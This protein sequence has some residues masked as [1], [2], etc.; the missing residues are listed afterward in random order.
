[1]ILT[2]SFD[3]STTL[4]G[5]AVANGKMVVARTDTPVGQMS[6]AARSISGAFGGVEN[7]DMSISE[8]GKELDTVTTAGTSHDSIKSEYVEMVY[9]AVREHLNYFRTIIAPATKT[10]SEKLYAYLQKQQPVSSQ[11]KIEVLE[12]PEPMRDDGF[13]TQLK[14][15]AGRPIS[16]TLERLFQME[17]ISAEKILE[18]MRTGNERKDKEISLWYARK[19]PAFF[20]EVWENVFAFN[21]ERPGSKTLGDML[22]DPYYRNDYALA[23]YLLANKLST[24]VMES[25]AMNLE[26]YRFIMDEI[27]ASSAT[28]MLEGLKV[29]EEDVV[30]D[31]VLIAGTY[32]TKSSQDVKVIYVHGASMRPWLQSGGTS[33][34]LLGCLAGGHNYRYVRDLQ[35]NKDTTTASYQMFL[36]ISRKTE[37]LTRGFRFR[38]RF[39]ELVTEIEDPNEPGNISDMEKAARARYPDFNNIFFRKFDEELRNLP[40]SAIA[41]LDVAVTNVITRSRFFYTYANKYFNN[42][43]ETARANPGISNDEAA[44]IATIEYVCAY[45]VDQL[46][47]VAV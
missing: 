37:E 39:R 8:F 28:A 43:M 2:S 24:E 4:A 40:D 11:L 14:R 31:N 16:R 15:F 35:E 44:L 34:Q 25:P 7:D 42:M 21:K 1:M 10:L 22:F 6:A 38:S 45:A 29:Y 33:E 47:V 46:E 30:R 41:Q 18:L 3:L 27:I 20:V 9:S 19:G 13:I 5:I 36:E 23:L 26:Q 17:L 12:L 32:T